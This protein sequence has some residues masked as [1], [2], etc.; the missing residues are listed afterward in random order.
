MK[1]YTIIVLAVFLFVLLLNKVLKT[2]VF[3]D[4]RACLRYYG[5]AVFLL[6]I[7]DNYAIWAGHWAFKEEMILGIR[8]LYM[9]IEQFVF[10][11]D[12]IFFVA[13]LWEYFERKSKIN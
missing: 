5:I 11:F 12:I 7:W 8:I 4:R 10:L 6:L 9:P 3:S 1:E 13:I 2:K